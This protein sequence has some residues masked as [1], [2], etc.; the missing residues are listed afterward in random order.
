MIGDGGRCRVIGTCFDQIGRNPG[1]Y[2]IV[3]NRISPF[4]PYTAGM[5]EDGQAVRTCQFLLIAIESEVAG[6]FNERPLILSIRHEG[7]CEAAVLHEGDIAD[8]A[9]LPGWKRLGAANEETRALLEGAAIRRA[10]QR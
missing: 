1:E 8:L 10:R 6:H 2:L 3:E 7:P 5:G 4:N 9:Y